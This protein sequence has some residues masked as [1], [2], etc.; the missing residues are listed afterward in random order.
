MQRQITRL[1]LGRLRRLPPTLQ[2]IAWMVLSG[3]VF[4]VL[5]A[6]LRLITLHVPPI[7]TQFL[8]YLSGALVMLPFILRAGLRAYNPNGRTRT[9]G[10][11]LETPP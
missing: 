7:E 10:Q 6:L 1:T 4:G 11:S 3:L 2:G 9:A 8:R 5:N